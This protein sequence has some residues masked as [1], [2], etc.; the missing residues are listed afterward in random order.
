MAEGPP[1]SAGETLRA[2][3]AEERRAA[4]ARRA[5]LAP[6]AAREAAQRIRD[7][8]LAAQLVGAGRT[9]S[10]YWPLAEELDPRPLM[11]ALEAR[12][13]ALALPVVVRR[14]EPLAFRRWRSGDAL[15]PAG[16]GL[17][18]PAPAAEIVVPDFLLVPLLAFDRAGRRLG[19]GAGFYDRT[20]AA[21]RRGGR[22]IFALGLAFACQELRE[23]PAGPTDEPLD[24]VATEQALLRCGE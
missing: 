21:L 5:A 19:H 9:V 20:L 15:V 22:E 13:H 11:L 12:G 24:A 1:V 17:S 10:G 16:F 23:V 4:Q 7:T 18:V 2:R 8:V 6:A 3:K 14:G